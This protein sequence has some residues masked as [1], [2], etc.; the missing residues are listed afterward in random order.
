[1]AGVGNVIFCG[2][3]PGESVGLAAIHRGERLFAEQLP[4]SEAMRFLRGRFSEWADLAYVVYVACE[5]Y[6]ITQR[7]ARLTR[8]PAA[9]EVTGVVRE[10]ALQLGFEFSQY[11]P[12]TSKRLA[13]NDRLRRLGLW[14]PR[15]PDASD[16]NDVND[17]MR[18]TVT[19]MALRRPS[20]FTGLLGRGSI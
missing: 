5:R 20:A 1:M 13:S 3:D 7:T 16:A 6:V 17:A 8:Q 14:T 10:D 9:L 18:Q 2:V 11:P 12:S 4:R 15:A 19:A